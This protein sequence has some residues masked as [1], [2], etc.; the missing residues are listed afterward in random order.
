MRNQDLQGKTHFR[1]YTAIGDVLALFVVLPMLVRSFH[2]HDMSIV[3]IAV[4]SQVGVADIKW[5]S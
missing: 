2:L 3:I 1:S 5:F 4:L